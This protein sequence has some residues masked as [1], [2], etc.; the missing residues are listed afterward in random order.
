MAGIDDNTVLYL[1]GDN[2]EDISLNKY[3]IL[4]EGIIINSDGKFGSCFDFTRESCSMIVNSDV[5][6]PLDIFTIDWWEKDAGGSTTGSSSFINNLPN[7][8]DSSTRSF[9]IGKEND[10]NI[11]KIWLSSD[12]SSWDIA[13]SVP[14]G[15][16]LLNEWVHRAVVNNG[17]NIKCYENGKL[18]ID[19]PLNEKKI[20]PLDEKIR[21]GLMRNGT[22][23]YGANVDEIRISNTV[24]WEDEF[25]PPTKQY[26]KSI[27]LEISENKLNIKVINKD[28]GK[29]EILINN[30]VCITYTNILDD[31]FYEIDKSK[32]NI[33]DNTIIARC[34]YNDG[35]VE[36][37]K[38]THVVNANMLPSSSS[39]KD[40]ID[41][42]SLLNNSIESQRLKLKNIL[43]SKGIECSDNDKLS[44][45][46]DDTDD[47]S[48]C[49]KIISS[50]N[51]QI[52]E[53]YITG[54]ISTNSLAYQERIKFVSQCEGSLRCSIGAHNNYRYGASTHPYIYIKFC[55]IRYNGVSYEEVQNASYLVNQDEDKTITHEFEDI[56]VGDIILGVVD[57]KAHSNYGSGTGYG[58]QIYYDII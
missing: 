9:H 15:S 33:G 40:V 8:S 19:I 43:I 6:L 57:R 13:Q 51:P 47:I 17:T 11:V 48:T 44:K 56:K 36:N 29:I 49:T 45:L 50:D 20:Y 38:L 23:S 54:R 12:N 39:L 53:N 4:N 58:G 16:I 14:I 27:D 32:C 24:I 5:R 22:A 35:Y 2:F 26:S 41:M 28:I 37:Y 52:P 3:P 7:S 46:I 55:V 31:F 42:Q 18:F 34:F 1:R 25:I 21:F 30:I 10:S